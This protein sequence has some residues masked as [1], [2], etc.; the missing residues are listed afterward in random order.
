MIRRILKLV[1]ILLITYSFFSINI[2]ATTNLWDIWLSP[3]SQEKW[4]WQSFEVSLKL[5][6]GTNDM[7]SAKFEINYDNSKV[8]LDTAVWISGVTRWTDAPNSNITVNTAPPT[9]NDMR[10]VVGNAAELSWTNL[11][12]FTIHFKTKSTFT[13]GSTVIELIEWES[14]VTVETNDWDWDFNNLNI[15]NVWNA[16]IKY[17][18][19]QP[20]VHKPDMTDQTDTWIS[21]TDDITS[22]T[23]P[24]FRLQCEKTWDVLTLFIDWVRTSVTHTCA[25]DNELATVTVPAALTEWHHAITYTRDPLIWWESPESEPLNITI[26]TTAPTWLIVTSPVDWSNI[27]DTTPTVTWTGTPWDTV[28]VTDWNW[29]TCTATVWSNWTWSCDISPALSSWPVTLSVTEVDPAWNVSDPVEVSFNIWW[30]GWNGSSGWGW[31]WT[32]DSVSPAPVIT[33]PTLNQEILDTVDTIDIK[34]TTEANTTVKLTLT[35][36][37]WHSV[38]V[39]TT[40]DSNWNFTV[41]ANISTFVK[42]DVNIALLATD[43]AWNTATTSTKFKIVHDRGANCNWKPTHVTLE[44]PSNGTVVDLCTEVLTVKWNTTP[45]SEVTVILTDSEWNKV[46]WTTTSD[47]NWNYSVDLSLENIV[48]W[49]VD[50]KVITKAPNGKIT[51]T[52]DYFIYW[53]DNSNYPFTPNM[54]DGWNIKLTWIQAKFESK[55]PNPYNKSAVKK[56]VKDYV[57]NYALRDYMKKIISNKYW[58]SIKKLSKHRV[59]EVWPEFLS[60]VETMES[61]NITYPKIGS[62][63]NESSREIFI[64]L[65]WI[66]SEYYFDAY[67]A[68]WKDGNWAYLA[69]QAYCEG[70]NWKANNGEFKWF[71]KI[72]ACDPNATPRF[73]VVIVGYG[74]NGTRIYWRVRVDANGN[75]CYVGRYWVSNRKINQDKGEYHYFV[76]NPKIWE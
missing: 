59:L 62:L 68:N 71:K 12:I 64:A 52:H 10:I 44:M 54:C 25:S 40:T 76:D 58:D 60:L 17:L 11:D 39:T 4:E 57:T 34:W 50:I 21:H 28:N 29:H 46:T 2:N 36:S 45:N 14:T 74:T 66:V 30:N 9:W 49:R 16:E 1:S 20:P 24:D 35:D 3:A 37:E 23:T 67:Y 75:P 55:Y 6:D 42:G 33:Y 69:W 13:S 5:N 26:D 18:I 8:E 41:P 32:D 61:N 53:S 31:G 48:A 56:V 63:S 22:D 15:H 73:K 7:D 72:N 70:I 51:I 43:Q 27:T 19:A 38:I 47:A 65:Y